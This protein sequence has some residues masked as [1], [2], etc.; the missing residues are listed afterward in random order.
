[1]T[2]GVVSFP[3][4]P[5]SEDAARLL[6]RLLLLDSVIV[7]RLDLEERPDLDSDPDLDPDLDPDPELDPADPS[8]RAVSRV[9][10]DRP[11]R[12]VR[13]DFD[14]RSDLV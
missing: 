14:V 10:D 12:V 1:M 2:N 8:V 7:V 9:I 5:D 3:K 6:L 13:P 4:L 11:D